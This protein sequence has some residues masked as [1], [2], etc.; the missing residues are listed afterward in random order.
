MKTPAILGALALALLSTGTARA[1]NLAETV[2]SPAF[3][4]QGQV[5]ISSDFD[6]SFLHHSRGDSNELRLRPALDYFIAPQLSLGGQVFVAYTGDK[7]SS[8]T[9]FGL[10]PRAGFNGPLGPMFS[11]YPNGALRYTHSSVSNGGGSANYL[12]LA[13]FAPFL[14]HPV[15]HFFIG[16][17][18]SLSV[19][20]AGGTSDTRDTAVGLETMIGGWFDW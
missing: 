10:A 3:G 15:Q 12:T 20:L 4:G 16:L 9:D 17:G 6:L 14:F 2:A 18:P 8:R 19:D 1:Q 13:L 7:G 5:A 11:P